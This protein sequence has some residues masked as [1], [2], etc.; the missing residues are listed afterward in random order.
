[1]NELLYGELALAGLDVA[2]EILAD[3]DLSCQLAP[4][5]GHLYIVLLKDNLAGV[6]ADLCLTFFPFDLVKWM[7]FRIRKMP[8]YTEPLMVRVAGRP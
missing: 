6:A 8:S 2:I 1:M 5:G 7:D 4:E 3:N